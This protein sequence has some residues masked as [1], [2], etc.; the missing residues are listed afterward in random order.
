MHASIGNCGSSP[1]LHHANTAGR[2]PLWRSW[3]GCSLRVVECRTGGRCCMFAEG[4]NRCQAAHCRRRALSEKDVALQAVHGSHL[5]AAS[6]THI[7]ARRKE[8]PSAACWCAR[9]CAA[10]GSNLYT[11][12]QAGAG[13]QSRA[14]W[15]SALL[16]TAMRA[17]LRTARQAFDARHFYAALGCSSLFGA[18]RPQLNIAL[19]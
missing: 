14:A 2:R 5:H 12:G 19:Q 6:Q 16:S 17:Q 18:Q 8:Q 1:R 3:D 7:A 10:Q 9:L 15:W 11:A 4:L 13:W